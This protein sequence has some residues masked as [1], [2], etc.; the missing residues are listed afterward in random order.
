M[1]ND[2]DKY[3]YEHTGYRDSCPTK[4]AKKPLEKTKITG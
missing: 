2:L 3:R 4:N 1:Y